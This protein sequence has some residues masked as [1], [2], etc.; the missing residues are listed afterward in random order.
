MKRLLVPLILGF[1]IVISLMTLAINVQGDL[2]IVD[3]L[4]A[5]GWLPCK[6]YW[7][8]MH[9]PIR[10][11]VALAFNWVFYSIVIYGLISIYARTTRRIK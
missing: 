1:V 2:W 4:L 3:T 11:L 10:A 8:I 5:P 6:W 9:D 7:G